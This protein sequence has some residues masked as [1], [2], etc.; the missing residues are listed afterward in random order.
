MDFGA[1]VH[2]VELDLLDVGGGGGAGAFGVGGEFGGAGADAGVGGG[3]VVEED[4][5]GVVV[6]GCDAEGK[7]V[8][9]VMV[10]L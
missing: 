2:G 3:D 4:F 5:L 7:C 10:I 1:G 9:L 8:L 6:G